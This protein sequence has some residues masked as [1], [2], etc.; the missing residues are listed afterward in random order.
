MISTGAFG[1]P[2]E[3]AMQIA[4][5]ENCKFLIENDADIHCCVR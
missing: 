1:Y 3:K 2:K 5:S 4:I